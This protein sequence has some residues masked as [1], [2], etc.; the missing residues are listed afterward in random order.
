VVTEPRVPRHAESVAHARR[1][2]F[3]WG[4]CAAIGACG[5]DG[6]G[7]QLS[8]LPSL[9][10][11][12][13]PAFDPTYDNLYSMVFEQR[14]GTSGT[15]GSCHGSLGKQGGLDLSDPDAAYEQLLGNAGG[16]RRVIP[17]DPSCS[18]LMERLES[19]DPN[20]RMP[21]GEAQLSPSVRCVVQT[22]IEDGA[23]R[24]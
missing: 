15:G 12:C 19:T 5:D 11:D 9:P 16:K 3:V 4:L 10:S 8:C 2:A 17:G 23:V 7:G 14:C 18:V 24:R 13:T 6:D 22:W 20:V 1:V 21:R